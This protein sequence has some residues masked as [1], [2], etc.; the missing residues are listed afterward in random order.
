MNLRYILLVFT[1][2]IVICGLLFTSFYEKAKQE[3]IRSLNTEQLLHARQAARGIEDFFTNWTKILTILSESSHIKNMDKT[4]KDDIE[5]LYK[6]NSELLRA[7]TRV[8]ANGRIIYT[9]PYDRNVMGRDISYQKHIREIMNTHKPVISDVFFAVQGYS[10]VALHMPVF[11]NGI[12]QGTV[13]IAINFQFLAKRYL[14]AIKIGKTGYAWVISRYGTELFCPIPG[15][16]G[17]SVFENCKNFPSILTMAQEMLKGHEGATIYTFDKIRAE[18]VDVVKKHAVYMPITIGNT[19]WSIVVASSENEILSSLEGFRNKLIMI[20]SFLLLGGILFSYYGL[21][22]WFIIREGEERRLVEE[23]LQESEQ[24]YRTVFEN[25]G[26]A[27]AILEKDTTISLCN[28]EFERLCGYAKNE[29]EGKKSWTEFVLPEDLDRMIAQHQIRRENRHQALQRYEFR[30]VRRTGEVRSI[31]LV[32]DIIHGTEK[33]VA[34]LIDIT[35]LKHAEEELQLTHQRLFD[36]IEFLPDATFVIDDKKKLVAW[37]LAC[38]KMTGVKK[39]EIIGKGDYAYAIPFYGEKRPIL[40]D[41]VIM[42]SGELQQ[43]Y[44]SVIKKGNLLYAEAFTPMLYKGKGAFLSGKASPLFNK[45]GKIVGAIESIRD[46]SEFK[47]L[48]TQLRQSRKM[49]AIGTLAGGIAHDFNNILTALMGYAALLRMN[50]NDATS[51]KY[52]DQIF[53][54]SHKATDLV[55]SLLTFSR[56]QAISLKPISLNSIIRGTEKLLKRLVTED[57]AIKTS[58]ATEDITIMADTTQIDQILFNLATNARDAMP[59]GGTFTIETEAI[60]LDDEFQRFHGYGIPGQYALLSISDTGVGMDEATQERIFDPFFTTKETGKGTGMGLS[61]VYG[62]VKQHNGYI[63]VYSEPNMGT[64]FRI[65]LPVVNKAGKEEKH[66]PAAAIGGNET[67]LVAEDDNA[68]RSLISEILIKYGYTVVEALDGVDAIEQFK[69]ADKIDLLIFDTV[70]PKKNGREAYNEIHKIKPDIKVIFTSGYT[71]D[72]FIDKGVED[73]KFNFL[74][75]P[76]ST[77]ALLQKI[78]E[79]LDERQGL[80]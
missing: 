27:T 57:I 36:I 9:I 59:Q 30:F 48:E 12:Y 47:H 78:R 73:K 17:N 15:H 53:S 16:V 31:Y 79:V 43:K 67:I 72:V 19:F 29:I 62:I 70:M 65:Y 34:S 2:F 20:I 77:N 13:A 37:N 41:L 40:I 46:I 35:E 38:E 60:S 44:Q 32:I 42:D 6:E 22:A 14:E 39:E 66:E 56:Q 23:A 33:S 71:R 7:V 64:T 52:V 5:N 80:E 18:T 3:S 54:A 25:T 24:R 4:G 63:T 10:T 68:V 11:K 76:V 26:A 8:D 61:T 75:K 45:T 1:F 49:E 51:Q 69:K 50:I 58:L 28:A 21:K 74:Q 55:Q